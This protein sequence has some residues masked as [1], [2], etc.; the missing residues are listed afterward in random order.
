MV[1]ANPSHS[2]VT[3][4]AALTVAGG[5]C[6]TSPP[7]TGGQL[8][9]DVEVCVAD[10]TQQRYFSLW[11]EPGTTQVDVTLDFGGGDAD[12]Y[13][14][15]DGWPTTSDYD[16]ASTN[17]GTTEAVTLA[18]PP[19]GWFYI[20]VE[21][22]PSHSGVTLKAAL[23]VAG[24]ACG[25][26]SPVTGGQI[27]D[28][29]E[30]CV[31]DSTQRRYFHLWVEPGTTHID[32]TL[33]FGGGDA[34]L[35]VNSDGWPTT[36]DYA[37]ASTNAGTTEAVTV[38]NPPIGW[39]YIM[40]EAD[41]SHSGVTLKADLAVTGGACGSSSPVT[42]GALQDDVGVCI[43]DSD[44]P[45]YFYTWV[46]AATSQITFTLAYGG[47]NADLYVKGGGWPTTSDYDAASTNAGTSESITISNPSSGWWYMRVED[48][49]DHTGVTLT[50]DQ[51]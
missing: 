18:N 23:T 37:A 25:M 38:L 13:V 39:F 28:D 30:V 31:A 16:A 36:S 11:I 10:A 41:P 35:Y 20:V 12:L 29:V 2:G 7:V 24:G 47:G 22:D 8:Q 32:V 26:S 6:G 46:G 34:D 1:E 19:S 42:G 21:A 40:I 51:Q 45:R 9:D 5:A 43:A 48:N 14:N 17:A 27:Q 44:Q 4:K 3:L 50:A 33:D 49:P 15:S